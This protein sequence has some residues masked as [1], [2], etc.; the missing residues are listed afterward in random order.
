M[1]TT[2][3]RTAIASVLALVAATAATVPSAQASDDTLKAEIVQVLPQITP[4]IKDFS[5]QAE[6]AETSGDLASLK[7]ATG[8]VRDAISLYKWSV[9]NRKAS[10]PEGLAAKKQLLVAIRE[11]DIG[12]AAYST[13]IDKVS[14]GASKASTVKSLKTFAKRIVAAADDETTALTALGVDE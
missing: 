6:K 13:A 9:I 14:G 4:V 2:A 5:A 7:D 8:K 3:R 11:Y 10:T 1:R 12:F